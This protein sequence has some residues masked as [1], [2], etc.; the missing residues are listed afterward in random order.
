MICP[1]ASQTSPAETV[2]SYVRMF[3]I[4][5]HLLPKNA[6]TAVI[7]RDFFLLVMFHSKSSP[8][9]EIEKEEVI[10]LTKLNEKEKAVLQLTVVLELARSKEMDLWLNSS[11]PTWMLSDKR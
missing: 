6:T 3:S 11:K 7:N 1:C 2:L 5:R 10:C 9:I 4:R 8:P